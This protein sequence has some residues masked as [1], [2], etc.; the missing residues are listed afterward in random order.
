MKGADVEFRDASINPNF[1]CGAMNRERL[2]MPV[3]EG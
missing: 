3:G 1:P 2:V